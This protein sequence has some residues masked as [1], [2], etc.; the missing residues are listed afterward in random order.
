MAHPKGVN[1]CSQL[2]SIASMPAA[3]AGQD[4]Q[5]TRINCLALRELSSA[6]PARSS[7]VADLKWN[8]RVLSLL[9]AELA[10]NV[11]DEAIHKARG[12]AWTDLDRTASASESG[13]DQ[14]VVKGEGFTE[15]LILLGRG[16]FDD[17]GSQD[18]LVKTLDTLTGG[19]YR[20]IRLFVLGRKTATARLRVVRELR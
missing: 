6:R 19:T 7:H 18:L 20:N 15:S 14:I 3:S 17:S 4:T 5:A 8:A 9:P 11:S 16:D 1:N 13:A 2:L 10:I 12:K